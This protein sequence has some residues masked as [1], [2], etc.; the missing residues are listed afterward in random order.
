M[1]MHLVPPYLSTTGKRKSKRKY[2]TA[3]GAR[4]ARDLDESWQ[5]LLQEHGVKPT[6]KRSKKPEYSSARIPDYR[7]YRGADQPRI[8]SLAFSG[9]ACARPADKVYSGGNILGIGTLHKSN[10]VPIFSSEEA[11]DIAKMRR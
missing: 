2:R 11:K 7:N 5:A 8:P 1:S 10:A 3:D 4:K 6:P 9:D